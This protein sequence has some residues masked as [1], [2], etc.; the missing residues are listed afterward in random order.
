MDS[1]AESGVGREI[2]V[3]SATSI[4]YRNASLDAANDDDLIIQTAGNTDGVN[5]NKK[6]TKKGS[7][8]NAGFYKS[9]KRRMVV[10]QVVER[11]MGGAALTFDYVTMLLVASFIAVAG[12]ATNSSV[13]VVASML[14]SPIMGPV[15]ALTFGWTLKDWNMFK[16]GL[17]NECVSLFVCVAVGFVTGYIW[18]AV[19]APEDDDGNLIWPTDEMKSRGHV[20]GLASGAFIAAVS[21]VGVALSVLGEYL[22][23]VIGVAISASLLPPAVNCG[24]LMALTLYG[25]LGPHDMH[26]DGKDTLHQAGISFLLTIL[27][28]VI[29]IIVG[30]VMFLIKNVSYRQDQNSQIWASISSFK[31]KYTQYVNDKAHDSKRKLPKVQKHGVSFIDNK[32]VLDA[33]DPLNDIEMVVHKPGRSGPGLK[34]AKSD[35]L[36]IVDNMDVFAEPGT[37]IDKCIGTVKNVLT[38]DDNTLNASTLKGILMRQA[39]HL[40]MVEGRQQQSR[41]NNNRHKPISDIFKQQ[42][43]YNLQRGD[44]SDN[45]NNNHDNDGDPDKDIKYR[46]EI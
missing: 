8:S 31:Q 35:G 42:Q 34:R 11:I 23:T 41:N 6:K 7:Y 32:S 27:N 28:I 39:S 45:N 15:L 2:G 1:L 46:I 20:P 3:V 29:I 9:I 33:D 44:E 5:T 36:A 14:V 26:I 16:M 13:I 10:K 19:S 17:K 4:A 40:E 12:L 38:I 22:S 21:G 24:M 37:D 18:F 43:G 25:E 30:R